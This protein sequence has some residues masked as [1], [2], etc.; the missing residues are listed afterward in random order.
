MTEERVTICFRKT[1]IL[2]RVSRKAHCYGAT[3][4]THVLLVKTIGVTMI[5]TII[6]L[7]MKSKYRI[8]DSSL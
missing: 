7:N 5:I 3:R 2:T 6:L 4:P 1:V 8:I